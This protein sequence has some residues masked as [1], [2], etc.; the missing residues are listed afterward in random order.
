MKHDVNHAF[1]H[2][3]ASQRQ[4]AL[5]CSGCY[6]DASSISALSERVKPGRSNFQKPR[7]SVLVVQFQLNGRNLVSPIA[8]IPVWP[9]ELHRFGH[10]RIARNF[11]YA[12]RNMF[13]ASRFMGVFLHHHDH[14]HESQ[15]PPLSLVILAALLLAGLGILGRLVAPQVQALIDPS[16]ETVEAR[17]IEVIEEG[18]L[19]QGGVRQPYQK[20][21][22]EIL[23]GQRAGR[24]VRRLRHANFRIERGAL[25]AR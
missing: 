13:C 4:S 15:R 14:S 18:T 24:A 7:F 12:V 9:H 10:G 2:P 17:V 3:S 23:S 1:A 11:T 22:L 25:P 19:D 5:L 8:H 6:R 20:L 16:Q 21:R